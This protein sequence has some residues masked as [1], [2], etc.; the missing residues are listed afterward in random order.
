MAPPART[1]V[2]QDRGLR[3][4]EEILDAAEALM[5]TRG[6]AGTSISALAAASGLPP[7]SIYWHFGSKAGVLSAVMERGSQRFLAASVPG[8]QDQVPLPRER[9]HRLFRRSAAGMR[10]HAPYLRLFVLLLLGVEGDDTQRQVITRVR[11]EGRHRLDHGLAWA[12]RPWGEQVA[13]EVAQRLGDLA[14][15]LL[16]GVF[17]AGE[18]ADDRPDDLVERAVDALHALAEGLRPP[19]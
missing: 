18:A 6:Y 16:D 12:Y 13:H 10:D 9:L 8:P 2:R 3:S 17:L 1:P 5:G 7:S 14:Q 15:A 19:G 11:A 4:R